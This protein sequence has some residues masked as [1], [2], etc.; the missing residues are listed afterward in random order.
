MKME[1]SLLLIRAFRR[2]AD[3]FGARERM[4]ITMVCLLKSRRSSCA[5]SD[6][7]VVLVV[8]VFVVFVVKRRRG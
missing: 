5:K 6:N 2:C 3:V 8:F 7:L 4:V 1:G